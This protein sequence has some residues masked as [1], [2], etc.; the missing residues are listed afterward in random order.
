[1]II[2]NQQELIK[3]C[4]ESSL[5][6][7]LFI[8]DKLRIALKKSTNGI[9]LAAPQIGIFKKVCIIKTNNGIE[10]FINPKIIE[11]KEPFIFK[12]EGCLSFPGIYLNTI[13]YNTI[14][15]KD[16]FGE[17]KYTNF[18]SVVCQHEIDHLNSI[19]FFDRQVPKPYEKCFCGSGNK[20]KFCCKSKLNV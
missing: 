11:K 15:V 7:G 4:E 14:L 10:I 5:E 3:P 17:K 13:R 6:E 16:E 8:A 1:M 19:L 12:K 2:T 9:G 20:F 18:A